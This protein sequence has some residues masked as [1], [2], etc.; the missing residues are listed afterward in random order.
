M[1]PDEIRQMPKFRQLLVVTDTAPP[2]KA[3]FPPV[4]LRRDIQKA[5][6]YAKPEVL[7]LGDSRIFKG[8]SFNSPKTSCMNGSFLA[9]DALTVPKKDAK[10]KKTK[11]KSVAVTSIAGNAVAVLEPGSNGD[12]FEFE[13]EITDRALDEIGARMAD[14]ETTNTF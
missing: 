2:V 7:R 12:Q 10:T 6:A 8:G 3:A 14:F 5:V 11:N 9:A 4:Y 1:L 13:S